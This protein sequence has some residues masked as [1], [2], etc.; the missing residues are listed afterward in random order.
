MNLLRFNAAPEVELGVRNS[1]LILKSVSDGLAC[2]I[3]EETCRSLCAIYDVGD[4][5]IPG[6]E[7]FA[8]G[9]V[10]VAGSVDAECLSFKRMSA[11]AYAVG[12][13]VIEVAAFTGTARWS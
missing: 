3:D 4:L 10:H 8:H 12:G 9:C 11:G 13:N 5:R 2:W 1:F 7:K 6:D